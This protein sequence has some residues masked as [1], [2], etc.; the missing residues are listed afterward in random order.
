MVL[1]RLVL[2]ICLFSITVYAHPHVFIKVHVSVEEEKIF[3]LWSFDEMSSSMLIGDYDKNKDKTFDEKEIA[4]IKKDHFDTLA[5]LSY[6]LHLYDGKVEHV[7]T[8]VNDFHASVKN[9][10]L[11]YLF[12]IP[13]P[14]LKEYELRFYDFDMYVGMIVK[15][16]FL[17]CK[18]AVK[19]SVKG[20]DA[21]Y[22]Y[23]YRVLIQK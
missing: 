12:S 15:P 7:T 17:T 16:E 21:D 10:K 18:E 14:L 23:G 9:K 11:H 8:K 3:V 2:G 1:W 22:Y 19:C 13:K 20:Y 5:S 6:F 4:F